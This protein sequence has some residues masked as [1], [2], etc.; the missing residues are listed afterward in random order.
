MEMMSDSNLELVKKIFYYPNKREVNGQLVPF[1]ALTRPTY[2]SN[3]WN[4]SA[5]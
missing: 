4:V 3:P 2:C 1:A 5:W